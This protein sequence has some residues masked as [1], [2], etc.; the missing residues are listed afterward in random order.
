MVPYRDFTP[1]QQ[2]L[3][4]YRLGFFNVISI[5]D[6]RLAVRTSRWALGHSSLV[7]QTCF[8]FLF[9]CQAWP[10]VWS[11]LVRLGFL[12]CQVWPNVWYSFA[13]F[14]LLFGLNWSGLIGLVFY[15]NL[16][17]LDSSLVFICNWGFSFLVYIWPF[18]DFIDKDIPWRLV[19]Y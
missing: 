10:L 19:W 9:I 16:L 3:P 6:F 4:V 18:F 13:R 17:G 2:L 15:L 12:F 8:L 14:C 11:S 7:S 1:V 5:Y